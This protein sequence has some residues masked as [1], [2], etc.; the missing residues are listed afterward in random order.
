VYLPSVIQKSIFFTSSKVQDETF[1]FGA[2]LNM[3]VINIFS[4]SF[5]I[6]VR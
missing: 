6:T 3:E 2:Q 5:K 1:F 4:F